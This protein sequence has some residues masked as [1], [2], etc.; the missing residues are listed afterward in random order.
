MGLRSSALAVCLVAAVV[1]CSLLAQGTLTGQVRDATG[2]PLVEAAVALDIGTDSTRVTRTDRQGRFRFTRVTE[3]RHIL[4][5]AMIG[6]QPDDAP[7]LMPDGNH[8]VEIVLE[9]LPF[10]LDTL[11]IVATRRGL[12]GTTLRQETFTLLGGVQVEVMG[13]R[14]RART[15]D[16]GRF[17]FPDL[18]EG[19]YVVQARK[20]RYKTRLVNGMVPERGAVEVAM[21]LDTLVTDQDQRYEVLLRDMRR[22]WTRRDA[23]TAAIVSAQELASTPGFPLHDALRYAPSVYGKGLIVVNVCSIYVDGVPGRDGLQLSDFK[24]DDILMAEVYEAR[25]CQPPPTGQVGT[26]RIIMPSM[27]S[28]NVYVW[29]KP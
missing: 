23:N 13:T 19:A 14:Y 4:R 9:R 15:R 12:I 11:P 20:D 10:Q 21:V 1:P 28:M 8:H 29:L 18:K 26:S 6:Y 22:R 25:P 24:A 27:P 3:G 16:D 17:E 2:R 7:I 5:T